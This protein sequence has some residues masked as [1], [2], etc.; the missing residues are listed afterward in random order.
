MSKT[1][2]V[3]GFVKKHKV[4]I[5]YV[6]GAIV[7]LVGMGVGCHLAFKDVKC[8]VRSPHIAKVLLDFDTKYATGYDLYGWKDTPF[9][10]KDLGKIGEELKD[11][12][13]DHTFTHI[14]MMGEK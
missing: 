1:E 7:G 3:L 2:K 9:G 8:F 10:A 6:T 4:G 12:I 13:G 5:A 14:I 11:V